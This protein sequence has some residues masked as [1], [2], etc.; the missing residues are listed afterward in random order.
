[1]MQCS[2][3]NNSTSETPIII[4]MICMHVVEVYI[5]VTYFSTSRLYDEQHML[6]HVLCDN[7]Q[8]LEMFIFFV[9]AGGFDII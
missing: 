1:M 2:L 5:I 6:V 3:C 9:V 8:L 4:I 7:E